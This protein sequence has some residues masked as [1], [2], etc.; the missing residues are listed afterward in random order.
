MIQ[1]L[2]KL[3]ATL[4]LLAVFGHAHASVVISG[5]RVIFP[6]QEREVTVN[7]S[8]TSKSPTLVQVW[9]DDG[10][11]EAAPETLQVPFTITPVLIRIEPEQGQAIRL[12]HSGAPMS[13]DRET[14][15]WLNML[16][17]PPKA[18][19]DNHL[20]LAFRTRIK[21]MYRPQGLPGKAADAPAEVTWNTAPGE[22]GK[23]LVLVG[24]NP[25]AYYVNMGEINVEHNGK[26]EALGTGYIAP[27]S[28]ERFVIKEHSTIST[29]ARVKFISI[30]DYGAGT[31][32]KSQLNTS[33]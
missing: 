12:I 1:S 20:Q 30:N 23:G 9:L 28:S 15:Y 25:T 13:K 33:N 11:A 16:E 2:P 31:T 27:F 7:L 24:H 22:N 8:N 19:E 14:L 17:V 26:S 4:A 6:A 32:N 3:L 18:Q 10:D 29:D 5:T 21:L